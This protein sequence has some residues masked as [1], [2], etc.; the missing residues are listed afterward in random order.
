MTRSE[1]P[2]KP[3]R[4]MEKHERCGAEW[5]RHHCPET[6][7]AMHRRTNDL[8]LSNRILRDQNDALWVLARTRLEQ[9]EQL[10]RELNKPTME[11]PF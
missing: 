9:I 2:L 8:M 1:A 3:S 4:L 11:P 6:V 7:D 5:A 10:E